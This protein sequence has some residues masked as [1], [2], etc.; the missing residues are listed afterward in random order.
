MKAADL[1]P[2]HAGKLIQWS[3]PGGDR[4]MSSRPFAIEHDNGW[5]FLHYATG[6]AHPLLPEWDV[7]VG[8]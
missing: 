1:N 8:R 2:T 3:R 7:E 5:V 6:N 4:V